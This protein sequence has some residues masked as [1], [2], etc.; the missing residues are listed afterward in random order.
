[1]E[2]ISLRPNTAPSV[3]IAIDTRLDPRYA[4]GAA[5]AVSRSDLRSRAATGD[6]SVTSLTLW[7]PSVFLR[8][9]A[10]PWLGLE[11]RVGALIYDPGI[12]VGNLFSDGAPVAPMLGLAASAEY[13]LGSWL[14]AGLALQYDVHRFTT[15]TLEN[16]GYNGTTV[17]H[18]LGLAVTLRHSLAHAPATTR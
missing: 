9:G 7:Q 14:L 8:Y 10:Q 5:L 1:M 3:G 12:T 2:A 18:R 16:R 4:V 15:S 17:V 13:P 11:A 6:A